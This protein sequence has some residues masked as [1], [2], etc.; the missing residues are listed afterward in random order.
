MLCIWV[1]YT[2]PFCLCKIILPSVLECVFFFVICFAGRHTVAEHF[3]H[4]VEWHLQWDIVIHFILVLPILIVVF[5]CVIVVH[6]TWRISKC[7]SA[8]L[9]R[10]ICARVVSCNRHLRRRILTQVVKEPLFIE[11]HFETQLT[12]ILA[13]GVDGFKVRNV[14]LNL[15]CVPP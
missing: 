4:I 10:A 15:H 14:I 3:H 5:V 6:P 13:M 12:H 9:V 8:I 1:Q 2:V 7:F 11:P